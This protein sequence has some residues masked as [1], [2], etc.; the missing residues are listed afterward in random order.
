MYTDVTGAAE[1][2]MIVEVIAS[3][4]LYNILI[5]RLIIAVINTASVITA[6]PSYSPLSAPS[7][8]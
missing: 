4:Q 6:L 1:A 2:V 5:A 7:P 8:P 3:P